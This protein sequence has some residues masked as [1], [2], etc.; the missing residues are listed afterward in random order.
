MNPLR[1]FKEFLNEG[2]AVKQRIDIFRAKSLIEESEKRKRFLDRMIKKL[3]IDE[4][5][6]NYY[7]EHSYDIIIELVRAKML[8]DGFKASGNHAHEAEVSYLMGLNFTEY[9]VRFVNELRFFRNGINYYGKS[10][11]A[12]YAKRVVKFLNEIYPKLI[13]LSKQS[14]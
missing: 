13:N 9:E 10:V 7:V 4:E 14:N 2:I 5:D 11:N 3:E 12:D 8:F 1:N 6:A